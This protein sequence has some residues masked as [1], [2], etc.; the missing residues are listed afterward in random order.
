MRITFLSNALKFAT[1]KI[2]LNL[3]GSN[4]QAQL[5]VKGDGVGILQK[6][7]EPIWNKFYQTDNSRNKNTNR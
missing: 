4:T 3:S 2:K 5:S 6:D 7:S 1:T